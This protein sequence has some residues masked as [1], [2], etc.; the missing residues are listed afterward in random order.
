[1]YSTT[2]MA[3]GLCAFWEAARRYALIGASRTHR[4]LLRSNK[5]LKG[6]SLQLATTKIDL[7]VVPRDGPPELEHP[8]RYAIRG[9]VRLKS[10][11]VVSKFFTS[12]R[13]IWGPVGGFQVRCLRMFITVQ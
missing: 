11:Q 10:P 9:L 6:K 3:E 7:S 8:V 5:L 1:M 13:R 4:P 12:K 2:G